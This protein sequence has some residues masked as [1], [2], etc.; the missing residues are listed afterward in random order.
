[1]HGQFLS[2]LDGQPLVANRVHNVAEAGALDIG[3]GKSGGDGHIQDCR[4][5]LN[6][7]R[8]RH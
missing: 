8:Q 4:I 1:M 7:V 3:I 2:V 5:L 6:F